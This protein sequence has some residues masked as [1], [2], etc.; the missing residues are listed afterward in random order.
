MIKKYFLIMM[1]F[2]TFNLSTTITVR[3]A[4]VLPV[5][6]TLIQS[7]A[8]ASSDNDRMDKSRFV[9]LVLAWFFGIHHFY[10]G[11]TFAGISY[12]V[13]TGL[14]G[15]GAILSFIDFISFLGM[16][17]NEFNN[18]LASDKAIPWL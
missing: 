14:F 11:N 2:F 3:T 5:S 18:Y 8:V 12:I 4:L 15:L 13:L 1:A 9:V 6:I 10:L 17:E 7:E 16:N